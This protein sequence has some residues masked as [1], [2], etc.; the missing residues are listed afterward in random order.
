MDLEL[1]FENQ[2]LQSLNNAAFTMFFAAVTDT[3]GVEFDLKGTADVVA[4]TAIGNVPIDDIPFDVTTSLK[5]L[6]G[7]KGLTTIDSVDVTGGTSQGIDLAIG[8]NPS[9]YF[10]ISH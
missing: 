10:L 4:R 5:G 3:A 8:G 9:P 1:S 6:Q 2:K 7:L